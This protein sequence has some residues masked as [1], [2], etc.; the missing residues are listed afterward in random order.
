MVEAW[1][2]ADVARWVASL[3]GLT[4]QHGAVFVRS[5]VTG[6]R[7]LRMRVPELVAAGLL[8]GP[9]VDVDEALQRVRGAGDGHGGGGG[10]AAQP[11]QGPSLFEYLAATTTW[12]G[13]GVSAGVSAGAA[14]VAATA[15]GLG[16]H[17]AATS[18][19]L[20]SHPSVSPHL[21]T[22]SRA[23]ADGAL[24]RV[25]AAGYTA[26]ARASDAV[27]DGLS[28]VGAAGTQASHSAMRSLSLR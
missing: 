26:G 12:A 10:A 14:V 3:P 15:A 22:F 20:A 8:A 9:A 28:A 4:R 18:E 27:I 5:E 16:K 19:R 25:H 11:Q 7:L 23:F 17:V 6:R 24:P 2:A 21:S 1:S 13:A